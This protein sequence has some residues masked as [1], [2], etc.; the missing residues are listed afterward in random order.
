MRYAQIRDMDIVNGKGI[1]AT[2]FFQGCSHRCKG[3]F[4]S[5]TWDFNGGKEWTKEVEDEFIK[6]CQREYID[7]ISILGGEPLDQPIDELITLLNRV[8][9]EVGKPIWLWS[10]YTFIYIEN[11]PRHPKFSKVL[12][13]VDYVI[14]GEFKEE[15]KDLNLLYRGS[16]NQNIWKK[17][18]NGIWNNI[19]D[20]K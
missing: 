10:G 20:I 11:S 3:C 13:Y 17:D 8:K 18:E 14:D 19:T 12:D 9:T 6:L 1:G 7:H 16:S 2:I 4:N 15:L 5:S